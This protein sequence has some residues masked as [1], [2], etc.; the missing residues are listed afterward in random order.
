[1]KSQLPE[2]FYKLLF[3]H[4][5]D[6][7][8]YCQVLFDE[9]GHSIDYI[10]IET[11]ENFEKLTGLKNVAGKKATEIIPTIG[12]SNPEL[13]KVSGRVSLTGKPES[14][15]TYIEKLRVW[16]FI[17]VYRIR[18]DFVVGILQNITDKKRMEKDLENASKASQNVL[19]DLSTEKAKAEAAEAKEKAL[20]ISIGDGVFATDQN[21]K[22]IL[23]NRTA[24]TLTGWHSKE[25]MGK[26]WPVVIDLETGD[27]IKV[28][29]DKRPLFLAIHARKTTTTTTSSSY[30][31]VRRNGT[32]FPVDITVSPVIIG[33]KIIG[34][35]SVFRDV[36]KEKAIDKTKT[37]FVSLASHQLRTP[38]TTISWYTEM[39]LKGD[40]GRIIPAQKKYLEKIY[41][42]NQQMIGLVNTLLNVSRIELGTLVVKLEPTDIIK[43]AQ[44]VLD[45]QKP[46]IEKKKLII[47]ES[48]A[49][50]VPTFLADPQ[51][52]RMVLQNLLSNAVEYTPPGGKIELAISYDSKKA[53]LI[54]VSDTGYGI[55][56]NQQDKIFT[57]LFRADNVRDKE[58]GGTGLGLYIVK[59]IVENSGGKIWFKS[60]ENKGTTFYVTLPLTKPVV[61]VPGSKS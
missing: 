47:K 38:L 29:P 59:S 40:V 15:E 61:G 2:N 31:Y 17:S 23:I 55:P 20:L 33:G 24:E 54:E 9:Q 53:I 12:E 35:I 11:N 48:F 19:E 7:L 26:I 16:L 13:F 34:A 44:N 56:K 42:G 36:T 4:M 27:G 43:L 37:E 60:K 22:V 14:F 30:F 50:D 58:I 49:K 41:Q 51:L 46:K 5:L 25:V 39:I 1:M 52:L 21:G 8:A 57:K 6:G 28:P 18:K 10:Y 45:E 32:K 3:D